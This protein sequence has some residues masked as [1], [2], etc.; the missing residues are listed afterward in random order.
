MSLL[1]NLPGCFTH[2]K[3]S[4]KTMVYSL[5]GEVKHKLMRFV[6]YLLRISCFL[7]LKSWKILWKIPAKDFTSLVVL[8]AGNIRA[9]HHNQSCSLCDWID[10]NLI[11]F[12]TIN[13]LST[14][15]LKSI[16]HAAYLSLLFSIAWIFKLKE[17]QFAVC[18]AILV[19][20]RF[21]LFS[22]HLRIT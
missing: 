9:A 17:S 5:T 21:F 14:R 1:H 19:F 4:L 16:R 15:S 20:F 12:F 2:T 3:K 6:K 10:N 13:K 22:A 7:V 11:T 8:Q 18:L